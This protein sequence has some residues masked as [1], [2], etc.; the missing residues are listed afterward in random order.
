MQGHLVDPGV[1][2][3]LHHRPEEALKAEGFA[4]GP[5]VLAVRVLGSRG[6][7]G[8]TRGVLE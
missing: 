6:A 2:G 3:A 7:R 8:E 4:L 1:V 5:L